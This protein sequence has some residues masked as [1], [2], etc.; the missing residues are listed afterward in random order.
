MPLAS[1]TRSLLDVLEAVAIDVTGPSVTL[2]EIF[3][4]SIYPEG[5]GFY[6]SGRTLQFSELVTFEITE[7]T[8]PAMGSPTVVSDNNLT[9]PIGELDIIGAA[10]TIEGSKWNGTGLVNVKRYVR[11]ETTTTDGSGSGTINIIAAATPLFKPA[12]NDLP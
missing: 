11:I 2:S 7:D 4:T 3:D 1:E 6:V 9:N 5:L 12:K 8:D 10:P